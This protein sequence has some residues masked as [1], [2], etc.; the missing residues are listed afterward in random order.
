MANEKQ[1]T[2]WVFGAMATGATAVAGFF[3]TEVVR[4]D[5]RIDAIDKTAQV[6]IAE[7]TDCRGLA[8]EYIKADPFQEARAKEVFAARGCAKVEVK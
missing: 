6:R 8:E 3:W 5:R 1:I 4:L 2:V 7:I